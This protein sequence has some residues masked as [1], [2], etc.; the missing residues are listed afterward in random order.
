MPFPTKVGLQ[1]ALWLFCTLLL[2]WTGQAAASPEIRLPDS[3]Q[4]QLD[5]NWAL[6]RDPTDALTVDQLSRPEVA[7]A[8]QVRD[9]APALGY[10][11]GTIWLR[12]TLNRP[13]RSSPVWL[14]E[15][16]SPL[17][18]DVTLFEPQQNGGY[19]QGIAGNR[20]PVAQRDVDYRDPVFRLEL[21]A[22]RPATVYLRVRSTSTMSFSMKMWTPEAFI[23][24]LTT[25]SLLFALF[26]ATHVVLVIFSM[27]MWSVARDRSFGYFGLSV[28]L[29]L[30]TSLGAEG[31]L[32]EYLL[33]GS[34]LLS[35]AIYLLSWLLGTSAGILFTAHYLGLFESRHRRVAVAA[36]WLTLVVALAAASCILV[37][38]VWWVRPLYLLWQVLVIVIS[39]AVAAWL[40]V[41]GYRPARVILLTLLLLLVGTALRVARNVGWIDP[42][43][44]V[45]NA[46]YLGMLAFML[47]MNSAIARRY[48]GMRAEKEAA[49]VEAL[50]VARQA[51][52]DLEA[53]VALR[54][55]ALR[56]AI[57]QVEVSLALERRAQDEQRQFLATVSHELRTPLAVIDA[58]AQN[59]NLDDSHI[60][61]MTS[62]RYQKIL[63]A[64]QR[65]TLLL[66]DSLHEDGFELL[67][68][69]CRPT[70]TRLASLLEDAATAA[71]LL[72]EGHRPEVD[73]QDLPE[74]FECD[75]S[76]LR[77]VLRTLADNAV[78]YTPEG[79]RIVLR[80][81]Q[82]L[83]G[84]E[85]AV[86]DDGPGI[87]SS[88]MPHVFERF[89]RGRNAGR[90]PG[91]GLG[92]SLAR[93]MVEMQDGSLNLDSAP[94]RGCRAIIFLPPGAAGRQDSE[95]GSA[96]A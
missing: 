44:I 73:A 67:R 19:R 88:D 84:V 77:L 29:N 8:F 95:R 58:T 34:P 13:A 16:R 83:H 69:G 79:T 11:K 32:Y 64:T 36:C 90:K 10:V 59:L 5:R 23:S 66:N 54:T 46:G 40:T 50:R 9:A 42:G 86:E 30:F 85:L 41:R 75:S 89:Y 61:P 80:G 47:I 87:D 71:S 70:P 35:N 48:T 12:L 49:Q 74:T 53:K 68:N 31:Y 14:L 62:A 25:E 43:P 24:S 1:A 26:Y 78:K 18:N 93:R 39:L 91:T 60:D 81:R 56:E 33:P 51:E 4:V 63:R 57:E 15:L 22:D 3:G 82:V 7:E 37:F 76:L 52:R 94:G 28:L 72:S 92:L 6:L 17:L 27:W 20:R 21:P 55:Q 96:N 2:G 45:D 65:L 38:D